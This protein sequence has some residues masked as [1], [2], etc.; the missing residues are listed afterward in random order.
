MNLCFEYKF[1]TFNR[2]RFGSSY[3]QATEDKL[4]LIMGDYL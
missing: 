4:S 3:F 2:V 1:E